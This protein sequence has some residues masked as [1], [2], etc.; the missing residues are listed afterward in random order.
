MKKR[1]GQKLADH[2]A[3]MRASFFARLCGL[4]FRECSMDSEACYYGLPGYPEQMRIAGHRRKNGYPG[5]PPVVSKLTFVSQ[6]KPITE[7]KFIDDICRAVG[8][9]YLEVGV[10]RAV[11]RL[12][13]VMPK[14][15]P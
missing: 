6:G 15:A 11:F 1:R 7:E 10:R 8:R 2:D 5:A 12:N 9:Y 13:N 4:E 14:A 3:I